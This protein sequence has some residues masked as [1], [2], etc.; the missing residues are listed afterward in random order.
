M[1]KD[2]MERAIKNTGNSHEILEKMPSHFSTNAIL[3]TGIE[4]LFDSII[5]ETIISDG[6]NQKTT[7]K[8]LKRKITKF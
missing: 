7:R 1:K 2:P 6:D 5:S 3:G 4:E 8:S